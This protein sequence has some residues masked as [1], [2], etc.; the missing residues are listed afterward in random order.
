[1]NHKI[2]STDTEDSLLFCCRLLLCLLFGGCGL[3]LFRLVYFSSSC[4]S[5]QMIFLSFIIIR[6][7]RNRDDLML[8]EP[9]DA[10]LD[11][12]LVNF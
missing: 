8:V 5:L 1:M 9:L 7:L 4:R 3:N 12:F 2:R 6:H 11:S 10:Q